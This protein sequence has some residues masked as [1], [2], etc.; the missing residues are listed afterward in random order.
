LGLTAEPPATQGRPSPVKDTLKSAVRHYPM[1]P[2]FVADEPRVVA[3]VRR[4]FC[5]IRQDKIS[6]CSTIFA[7]R[8]SP[9]QQSPVSRR[10]AACRSTLQLQIS[11]RKSTPPRS[12]REL[13]SAIGG[14]W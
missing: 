2:R 8:N 5:S 10:P 6:I 11:I 3:A 1:P 4:S 9:V 12:G 13:R 14:Q 7:R